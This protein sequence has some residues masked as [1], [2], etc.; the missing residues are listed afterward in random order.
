MTKST[1]ECAGLGI[2]PVNVWLPGDTQLIELAGP[3]YIF[4]QPTT[5]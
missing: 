4:V 1:K 3:V 2:E 5:L